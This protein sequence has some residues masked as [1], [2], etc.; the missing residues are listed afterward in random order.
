MLNFQ[1]I[2]DKILRARG[3][4]D[5]NEAEV[6]ERRLFMKYGLAVAASGLV[7][8]ATKHFAAPVIQPNVATFSVSFGG[9]TW[10]IESVDEQKVVAGVKNISIST[11][12]RLAT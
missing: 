7:L 3:S 8:P 10:R 12:F 9:S 5:P 2:K 11:E 6:L 1:A 4:A